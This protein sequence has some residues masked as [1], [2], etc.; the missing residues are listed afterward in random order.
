MENGLYELGSYCIFE[1]YILCG[2]DT[3]GIGQKTR[4]YSY[5][6][7]EKSDALVGRV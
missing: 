7:E 3:C 4:T 2:G 5:N 1:F 6:P